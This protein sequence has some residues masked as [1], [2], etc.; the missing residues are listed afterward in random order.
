M[1]EIMLKDLET[2][3]ELDAEALGKLIGG[4]GHCSK[5][6]FKHYCRHHWHHHHHGSYGHHGHGHWKKYWH[7]CSTYYES[8]HESWH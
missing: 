7:S 4:W 2:S 1:A 3:E 8:H 5:K 6:R